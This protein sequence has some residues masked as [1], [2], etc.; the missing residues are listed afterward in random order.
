MNYWLHRI[1]HHAE[2]S[3]PLLDKNILSI[4][5]SDFSNQEFI[6]DI[7]KGD[8]WESRWSVLENKFEENWPENSGIEALKIKI[9]P[10]WFG[11]R[12][13]VSTSKGEGSSNG[14]NRI[15]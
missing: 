9:V 13:S 1:S 2:V 4:G 12:F 8:T 15:G 14:E 10:Q 7:L 3:Y 11:S 6:D 5:F